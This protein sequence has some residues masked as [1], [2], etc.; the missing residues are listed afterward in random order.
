M[1][2]SACLV[3]NAHVIGSYQVASASIPNCCHMD[4]ETIHH[5]RALRSVSALSNFMEM[6][7][8]QVS[9]SPYSLGTISSAEVAPIKKNVDSVSHYPK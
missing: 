8:K 7:Y 2:T 6:K 3:T 4:L 5:Q 1:L 9:R